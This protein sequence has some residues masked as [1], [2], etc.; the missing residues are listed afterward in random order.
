MNKYDVKKHAEDLTKIPVELIQQIL[1][2]HHRALIEQLEEEFTKRKCASEL[3]SSNVPWDDRELVQRVI[4]FAQINGPL[5][6]PR[7]SSVAILFACTEVNARLICYKYGFDP[8]N[9]VL[10]Y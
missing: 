5:K 9:E 8:D 7:W 2:K 4:N 3:H 10:G 1:N 6:I